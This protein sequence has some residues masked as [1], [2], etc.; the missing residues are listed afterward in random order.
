MTKIRTSFMPM[1]YLKGIIHKVVFHLVKIVQR[2]LGLINNEHPRTSILEQ[3]G[4]WLCYCLEKELVKTGL[5]CFLPG[6]ASYQLVSAFCEA[7]NQERFKNNLR[8]VI[9]D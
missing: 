6:H 9:Y 5:Y 8:G 7:I 2:R 1:G 3:Q 4:L